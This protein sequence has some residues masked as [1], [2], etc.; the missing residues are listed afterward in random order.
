VQEVDHTDVLLCARFNANGQL[1]ATGG[2][3]SVVRVYCSQQVWSYYADIRKNGDLSAAVSSPPVPHSTDPAC[4][5]LLLFMTYTG[6]QSEVID[7][8]WSRFNYLLSVS[9]DKTVRLWHVSQIVCLLIFSHPDYVSS[10]RFLPHDDRIFVSACLDGKVRLWNI[11]QRRIEFCRMVAYDKDNRATGSERNI[12]TSC[13]FMFNGR[14]LVLGTND[15]RLLLYATNKLQYITQRHVSVRTSPKVISMECFDRGRSLLITTSDSV[16]RFLRWREGS[17]QDMFEYRGCS[18]ANSQ[19]RSSISPDNEFVVCGSESSSFY[20]WRSKRANSG[21]RFSFRKYERLQLN[22]ANVVCTFERTRNYT[23]ATVLSRENCNLQAAMS[24][25]QIAN[26]RI[27]MGCNCSLHTVP[28]SQDAIQVTYAFFA[29]DPRVF[30]PLAQY[31]IVS[32]DSQG[33]IRVYIKRI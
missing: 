29:P 2:L 23:E 17:L 4:C 12:V 31:A 8:A 27:H 33:K 3:D 26:E 20:L 22:G 11:A 10:V 24:S 32:I 28:T 13:C 5:K 25:H 21:Y 1:M 30:D 14:N 19:I 6:H 16:V 7:L 18:L 9:L 15:G